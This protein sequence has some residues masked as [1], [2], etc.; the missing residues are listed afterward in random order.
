MK[1]VILIVMTI[2]IGALSASA[3]DVIVKKSGD[4]VKAKISYVGPD[5][6]I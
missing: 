4:T 3:Q 5:T 6:I 2:L 1:R